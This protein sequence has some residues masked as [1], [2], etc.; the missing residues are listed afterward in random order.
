MEKPCGEQ[1]AVTQQGQEAGH[2]KPGVA[3]A[4]GALPEVLVPEDDV[5]FPE[6]DVPALEAAE[7]VQAEVEEVSSTPLIT[8][9]AR[10]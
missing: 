2:V 10:P 3:L 7:Q 5:P 4:A 8:L 6:M 9:S 1:P